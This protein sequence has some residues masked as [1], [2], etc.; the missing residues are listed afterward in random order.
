MEVATNFNEARSKLVGDRFNFG[1]HDQK[2]KK[3]LVN[4]SVYL[5]RLTFAEI[6]KSPTFGDRHSP[7]LE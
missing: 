3:N 4:L 5:D 1:E 7:F 6:D 2:L